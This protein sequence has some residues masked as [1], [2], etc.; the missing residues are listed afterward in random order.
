MGIFNENKNDGLIEDFTI[1]MP[2]KKR[3]T[4]KKNEERIQKSTK[5][6]N[7][8]IHVVADATGTILLF[9]HVHI[10]CN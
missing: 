7:T 4:R 9:M 5:K 3:L 6:C 2:R 10:L 8:A 1:V